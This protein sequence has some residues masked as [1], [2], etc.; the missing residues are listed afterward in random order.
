M[1]QRGSYRINYRQQSVSN[2]R[3]H[4][5]LLIEYGIRACRSSA[6]IAKDRDFCVLTNIESMHTT[7]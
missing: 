5:R 3:E 2:N 7:V 4:L 1:S 6:Y